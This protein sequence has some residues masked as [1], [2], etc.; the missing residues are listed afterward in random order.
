MKRRHYFLLV[1]PTTVFCPLG[2]ETSALGL[3]TMIVLELSFAIIL[4]TPFG[5]VLSCTLFLGFHVSSF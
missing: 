2:R 3:L 5:S 1:L 4:G